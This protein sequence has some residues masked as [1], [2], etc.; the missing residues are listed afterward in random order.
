MPTF[1]VMIG[2][3]SHHSKHRN[4][5]SCNSLISKNTNNIVVYP[6]VNIFSSLLLVI[7]FHRCQI[8]LRTLSFASAI[9]LLVKDS[10]LQVHGT[11][12]APQDWVDADSYLKKSN[13]EKASDIAI[14]NCIDRRC[15]SAESETNRPSTVRVL[16]EGLLL[17]SGSP[18]GFALAGIRMAG[19]NLDTAS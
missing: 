15:A 9:S 11:G 19:G 8:Q 16:S 7:N 3:E 6:A 2:D 4:S 14:P 5:V 18:T 1:K 17:S 10:K 12:H 13:L